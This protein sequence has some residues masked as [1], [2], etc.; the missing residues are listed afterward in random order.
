MMRILF[1]AILLATALGLFALMVSVLAPGGWTIVKALILLC[2][3]GIVPW[4]GICV[5][6]ALLGFAALIF[7]WNPP[8]AVLP[9]V[10][11]IEAGAI[12]AKIALAVTIRNEPMAIVLP[13][14]RALLA[15]LDATGH[16][17]QF[18]VFILSDSADGTAEQAAIRT[19]PDPRIHYRRRNVNTG[20]K[21]GN[22]MEF[23]DQHA[24]AFPLTIMLDADSVMT[25]DAILRLVRIMQADPAMGVVQHLTVGLPA[26]SAFPRLFQFGMRAGMRSWATGQALWQGADGPYWGHNAILRSAAFRDHC[27]LAPLPDGSPILS[28]DQVEAA[29][30]RCAGFK[31]CVWAGEDGSYEA[32]P[33]ALPEFLQ[34]DTRW[35]AG[36][37]QYRHLLGLPGFTIMGRWQLVQAMLLFAGAPLYTAILLLAA[38]SAATGGGD[39][40]RRGALTALTI[41][42]PLALY[43]PKLLAYGQVLLNDRVRYGGFWQFMAGVLAETIFTLLLDAV[44][45]IHKTLVIGR[46]LLGARTGWLVQ[47]R[48]DRGVGWGEA[49]RMFWPHTLIGLMAFA[50][51]AA[52][53]WVMVLW[54][55]PWTIGLVLAI[56]FCVVTAHPRFSKW[57]AHHRIAAIPEELLAARRASP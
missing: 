27:K 25:A 51:F 36:N 39:A 16:G 14:L 22:V 2:F 44:A 40:T 42:W 21:A 57:L 55:T 13:P 10:G 43:A 20:F 31:V 49:A 28:H 35:L 23:L 9:V 52:S 47:N 46:L 6:N 19:W 5:G 1:F 54:A 4:L 48:A 34:R 53:S 56:P 32:N 7:A 12:T 8:R 3:V 38:L 11:N 30:M 33:P 15:A 37:M 50:G 26:T 29:R 24:D 17:T 41:A 45:T 18:A